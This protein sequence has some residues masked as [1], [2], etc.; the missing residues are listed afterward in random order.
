MTGLLKKYVAPTCGSELSVCIDVSPLS[1]MIGTS[2]PSVSR[3]FWRDDQA[4]DV[5]QVD[6]DDRGG[7]LP[8]AAPACSM[9]SAPRN[10]TAVA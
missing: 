6:V 8:R 10:A 9:A 4:A 7:E 1:T 3:S 2:G 5:G